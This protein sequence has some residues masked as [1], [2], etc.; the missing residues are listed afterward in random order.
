M[1]EKARREK[2]MPFPETYAYRAKIKELEEEN[3]SLQSEAGDIYDVE[4][5]VEEVTRTLEAV[6]E[7]IN[8]DGSP[9]RIP[10]KD[11]REAHSMLLR[12]KRIC[13]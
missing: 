9:R 2:L 5:M 11:L 6:Q 7:C 12:M 10:L 13:S 1:Y 8:D 3:E 4:C